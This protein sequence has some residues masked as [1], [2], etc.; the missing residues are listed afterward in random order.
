MT[1]RHIVLAAGLAVAALTLAGCGGS[2][3]EAASTTTETTT[4]QSTGTGTTGTST[5]T[6]LIGTVGEEGNPDAFTITLTTADGKAVTTLPAGAYTLEIKDLSTI[7]DFH[8]TGPGNVD[9]SSDV[10]STEDKEVPITL[11]AGSYHYQC[12][13]HASSMNGDFTVTG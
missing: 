1:R 12:D 4:T 10:G 7:H 9:V 2:N 3:N 6:K 5:N 11:V 8:L 13:P